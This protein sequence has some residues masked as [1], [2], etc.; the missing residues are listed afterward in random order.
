MLSYLRRFLWTVT[1]AFLM[2]M[3]SGCE[4]ALGLKDPASD[5]VAI[6][7][8]LWSLMDKRYALFSVKE[9][10]WEEIY[11]EY[12]SMLNESM[13]EKSLFDTMVKML[14]TLKDGHV[15]L[16][17]SYDTATY[18]NFYTAYPNN[19]NYNNLIERYLLNDYNVHGPFISKIVNNIGYVYY[20][21]FYND[22]SDVQI[23]MVINDMKDVRGLIVDVRGNT[24]GRSSNVNKLFSRFI[25]DKKLVKYELAKNGPGHNDF[26][27]PEPYYLEPAGT[28]FTKPVVVLTN[29]SCFS[30]CNDFVS[31][32]AELP[33]VRLM[34]DQTGG[35]GS[36]PY[37]Y[38]LANGWKIQYSATL[39]LSTSKLSIEN[40]IQPDEHI[41]ITPI[42]EANGRDPILEKAYQSLQ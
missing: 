28:A 17:S 33:N 42:D 21:S 14:E 36:V 12:R 11:T 7:D 10:D 40:G 29:R 37:N 24:G 1:I 39:T 2:L 16:M 25:S 27:D 19:F 23:D 41:G 15:T 30:G 22:I 13:T 5:P 31:Y 4:K 3:P 18:D 8:E 34:G 38:T 26:S 9:V 6:F 32:M 35:G 20:S